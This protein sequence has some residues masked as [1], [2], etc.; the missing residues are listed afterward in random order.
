M[1]LEKQ[2]VG[3]RLKPGYQVAATFLSVLLFA[4]MAVTMAAVIAVALL[5][6][7]H[8]I[9]DTAEIPPVS[10]VHK[11]RHVR[12]LQLQLQCADGYALEWED[13]QWWCIDVKAPR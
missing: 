2:M 9:C 12:Q 1:S 3:P 7:L 5:A 13:Q 8:A 6:G 10:V 4:A 11:Q